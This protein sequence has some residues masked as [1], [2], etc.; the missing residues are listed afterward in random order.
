[1]D[2]SDC[3]NKKLNGDTITRLR[4]GDSKALKHLFESFYPSVC[5]Y[6]IKFIKNTDVAE[7]IAQDAFVQYWKNKNSICSM[8]QIQSFIYTTARNASINYLRQKKTREDILAN[9][10]TEQEISYELLIEEESYRQLYAA[11]DLL[12]DRTREVICLCL[13]G[14][15]NPEIAEI[16]G[17]SL[18][19]IKSLKKYAYAELR[20]KLKNQFLLILILNQ[21]LR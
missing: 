12:P 17:V 3:K 21:L 5:V 13:K 19:T 18:N 14:Y 6:I 15:K 8:Q 2:N 9:K 4:N 16:L 7:D 11:I 20:N 1:V 10:L